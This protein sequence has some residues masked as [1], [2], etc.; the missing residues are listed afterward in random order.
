M[1]DSTNLQFT[2]PE[3]GSPDRIDL[4]LGVDVFVNILLTGQRYGKPG[5]L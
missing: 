3:F 2:D 4:L 1:D 5:T